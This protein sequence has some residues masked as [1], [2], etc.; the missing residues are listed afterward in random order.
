MICW[1]SQVVRVLLPCLD[2]NQR[3]KLKQQESER[4][5]LQR[6]KGQAAWGNAVGLGNQ[7]SPELDQTS[8][9]PVF[10]CQWEEYVS[11]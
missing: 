9:F 1:D 3:Q 6:C 4:F 10:Y 5:Y 8:G 11:M 7:W 2:E